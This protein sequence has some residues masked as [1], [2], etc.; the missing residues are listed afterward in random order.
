MQR[1]KSLW[2]VWLA[3]IL[4]FVSC[5]NNSTVFSLRVNVGGM[6]QAKSAVPRPELTA[7]GTVRLSLSKMRMS[8]LTAPD[9]GSVFAGWE[10]A[11]T[12]T[13][14]CTLTMDQVYAVTTLFNKTADTGDSITLRNAGTYRTGI[15]DEGAAEIA[16]FD[17]ATGRIFVVNGADKTVDIL[18]SAESGTLLS[19]SKPGSDRFPSLP[20]D[21][22]VN[23]VAVSQDCGASVENEDRQ[24]LPERLYFS[25][26]TKLSQ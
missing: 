23:S 15:F 18:Q 14:P 11:C 2:M 19:G 9:T 17:P 3:V 16:A 24:Q 7:K 12:G 10:G 4:M 1:M 20:T 25:I 8:Q 22:R 13:E 26:Q 5:D 6:E 21:G